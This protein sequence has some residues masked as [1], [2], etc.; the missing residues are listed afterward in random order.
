MY[1]AVYKCRLCGEKFSDEHYV[2]DE[3]AAMAITFGL[4]A[5]ESSKIESFPCSFG[6]HIIHYCQDGSFGLSDFQGFKRMGD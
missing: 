4:S 1:Q 2:E 3:I 5:K 6:R